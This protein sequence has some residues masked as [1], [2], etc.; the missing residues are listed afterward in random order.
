MYTKEQIKNVRYQIKFANKFI[1]D[2]TYNKI[3]DQN[4]RCYRRLTPAEMR[5]KDNWIRNNKKQIS[6]LTEFLK[7][8]ADKYR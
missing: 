3:Y 1:R 7:Y 4:L 8:K 6:K 2:L 5:K